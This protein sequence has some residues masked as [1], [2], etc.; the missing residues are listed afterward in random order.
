M[1]K[2]RELLSDEPSRPVSKEGKKV[3]VSA[4]TEFAKL[5]EIRNMNVLIS[6]EQKRQIIET[7]FDNNEEKYQRVISI[8]NYLKSWQNATE[9]LELIFHSNRLNPQS[10]EARE[11]ASIVCNCFDE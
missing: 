8:F 1:L 10:G 9:L 6:S 2:F 3:R 4:D 11:F 5:Y 7:I